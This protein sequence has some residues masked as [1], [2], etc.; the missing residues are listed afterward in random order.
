[1]IAKII[2]H[3]TNN[4]ILTL[5][6]LHTGVITG[7]FFV[8][9]FLLSAT[10]ADYKESERMP[11]EFSSILENMYEDAE[12]THAAYSKF[13]L[14]KFRNTLSEIAKSFANGIRNKKH[15]ARFDIHRLN[16]SF[17]QME[18]AGVPPNYIVKLKQQQA[19]LLKILFRVTYIQRITFI[20]SASI[21]A[22]SIIPIAIGFILFTEIE[23]LMGGI[24]IT[25]V[26]S[27][28]LVYMLRLIQV[29]STPF[30]TEGKTQDDVSLFLIDDAAEH[31]STRIPYRK[32]KRT[33]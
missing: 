31:L 25:A 4:E 30:Q 6:S 14:E 32:S 18:K 13:D 5:G 16:E 23:P 2:L 27:F 22:K 17:V 24:I 11:S 21:L 28:I 7:T 20:P 26:I 9:G 12:A 3:N 15:T 33:A 8:L 10:I 29:I 1:V 19:Q